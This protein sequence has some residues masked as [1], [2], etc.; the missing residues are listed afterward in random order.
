MY[1]CEECIVINCS[2]YLHGAFV[3]LLSA[4]C[5]HVCIEF[6]E[7]G[8][9]FPTRGALMPANRDIHERTSQGKG[10]M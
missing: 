6:A 9:L 5:P 4:V 10:Q 8:V 7:G 1:A 2:L 3:G